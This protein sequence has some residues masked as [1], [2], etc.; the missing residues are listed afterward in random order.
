VVFDDFLLAI[1]NK[2]TT[3]LSLFSAVAVKNKPSFQ[4]LLFSIWVLPNI[5]IISVEKP[6][7]R[8]FFVAENVPDSCSEPMWP[9]FSM[10]F[11]LHPGFF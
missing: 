3:E 6:Y 11:N 2:E 4:Y 8:W 10:S 1:E 7:F 9:A 5:K